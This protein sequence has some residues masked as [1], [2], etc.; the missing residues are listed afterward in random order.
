MI[1]ALKASAVQINSMPSGP[2]L[3]VLESAH[4]LSPSARRRH[5]HLFRPRF[6]RGSNLQ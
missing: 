1:A 2:P 3:E 4:C 6:D 5:P